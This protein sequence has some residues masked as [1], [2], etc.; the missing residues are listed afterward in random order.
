MVILESGCLPTGNDASPFTPS[1]TFNLT[2]DTTKFPAVYNT[3][4]FYMPR[5][6]N[7]ADV[8]LR[9]RLDLCFR[10]DDTSCTTDICQVRKRRNADTSEDSAVIGLHVTVIGKQSGQL[11][12]S[13]DHTLAAEEYCIED[14]GF[15]GVVGVL[16]FLVLVALSVTSYL[17][18][19]VRRTFTRNHF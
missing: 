2:S 13:Q 5:Y 8:Y 12:S 3:G 9:C 7:K 4:S 18:C 17:Y 1:S 19:R 11:Q 16:G 6:E 15:L 14:H 10:L